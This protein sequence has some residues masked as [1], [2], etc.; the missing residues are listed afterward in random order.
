MDKGRIFHFLKKE[1]EK[2]KYYQEKCEDLSMHLNERKKT[3]TIGISCIRIL[4]VQI[5]IWQMSFP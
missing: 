1:K 5:S 3:R 4:P 2:Y